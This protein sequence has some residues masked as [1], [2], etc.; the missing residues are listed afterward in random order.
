MTKCIFFFLMIRR[1]PRSTLFPYTT[2]FRSSTGRP[3]ARPAPR[4]TS[5]SDSSR[6]PCD[7]PPLLAAAHQHLDQ[8]PDGPPPVRHML[9]GRRRRL[10]ERLAEVGREEQRVVAEAARAARRREDAAFTGGLDGL[11]REPLEQERVVRRLALS[12]A[13]QLRP[14]R[15]EHARRSLQRIDLEPRVLGERRQV[16]PLREVT[17]LRHRVLA[18]ARPLLQLALL[19]EPLEK[20]LRRKHELER[21]PGERLADLPR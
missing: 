14:A 4:P 11:A 18:E 13:V 2:L 20:L 3:P 19:R 1:P 17:G 15:R 6:N 5:R 21:E 16:R 8:R 7:A 10:A 9:L 12:S